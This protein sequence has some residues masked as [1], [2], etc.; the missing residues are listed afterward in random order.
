MRFRS[1]LPIPYPQ[2]HPVVCR[3]LG[4]FAVVGLTVTL[5]A[6]GSKTASNPQ[7]PTTPAPIASPVFS[8]IASPIAKG[9]EITL[10]AAGDSFLTPLYTQ[11]F[12]AFNKDYP[13]IKVTYQLADQHN[14]IAAFADKTADFVATDVPLESK[15]IKQIGD[16]GAVM[17]P[18]AASGIGLVYNLPNIKSGLKLPREVYSEIWLGRITKWNHP[19]IVAANPTLKLPNL[20]ITIIYH[21]DSNGATA[22]LTRHLSAVNKTWKTL[23]GEGRMVN[24][25]TG[26]GIGGN[27]GVANLVKQTQGSLS[28]LEYKYAEGKKIAIAALENQSGQ[29]VTP[30][31]Q[32]TT[33][34]LA[35]QPIPDTLLPFLADPP[36]ADAYPLVG[37]TWFLIPKRYK[38]DPAPKVDALKALLT[39]SLTE[40]QTLS[41]SSGYTP[42]SGEALTKVKPVVEDIRVKRK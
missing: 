11:W 19:A 33:T 26:K 10:N 17:V 24:W 35:T 41:Q 38:D 9:E 6:C 14:A 15:E 13:N 27:E 36:G 1:V 31:A 34:A 21:T 7:S 8:P 28:Y 37:Y 18:M 20:P 25:P 3:W 39:W 30:T 29:F 2:A 22:I 12:K 16:R 32:S 40:G 23:F 42:L 4:R 5:T